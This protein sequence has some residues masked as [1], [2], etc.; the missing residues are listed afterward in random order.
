MEEE[1]EQMIEKAVELIEAAEG[2]KAEAEKLIKDS[3]DKV[4]G[5]CK[6][7]KELFLLS[8]LKRSPEDSELFRNKILQKLR[9]RRIS[10]ETASVMERD[11]EEIAEAIKASAKIEEIRRK[12]AGPMLRPE[13]IE[14]I[15]GV[16]KK[17]EDESA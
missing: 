9:S 4:K 10:W 2:V 12:I 16:L 17:K 5:L 6:F 8:A 3:D 14:D 15:E 1:L 7:I 11:L 13:I